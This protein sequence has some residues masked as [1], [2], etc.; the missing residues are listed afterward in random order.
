[1]EIIEEIPPPVTEESL[2]GKFSHMKLQIMAKPGGDT[3][4]ICI[5]TGTGRNMIDRRF[6]RQ[7]QHTLHKKVGGAIRGYNGPADEL[8]EYADFYF[9]AK[10]DDNKLVKLNAQAWVVDKLDANCLLGNAWLVPRSAKID[11]EKNNIHLPNIKDGITLPIMV[12]KPARSVVRKVTAS[13]TISLLPGESMYLPV[14]YIALPKGRSFMLSA[15][16]PAVAN[17]L[18][19]SKTPTV[20]LATNPTSDKL[21]IKRNTRLATIHECDEAAYF[22]TDARSAFK[23]L[24]FATALGAAY[25][26]TA[27]TQRT[28]PTGNPDGSLAIS[29]TSFDDNAPVASMGGEFTLNN[30]T[31]AVCDGQ[32]NGSVTPELPLDQQVEQSDSSTP[33][34]DAVYSMIDPE[35][36]K[37]TE[38]P[39]V[40]DDE[41]KPRLSEINTTLGIKAP[42]NA[43]YQVSKHGVRV[44]AGDPKHARKFRHLCDLYPKVWE[45]KGPIKVPLDRQMKVPLVDGYQNVKLNSRPYPLSRRDREVLDKVH[46]TL[47]AQGRM[48]WVHE[49]STFAHPVFVVWRKVHGE[50]KGRAVVDLRQLNKVAVPDSYPL[51]LVTDVMDSVRGKKFLTIVDAT[52]FFFQF[53][54]HPQHRDRF[55]IVSHRGLERSTVALMGFRNS[56][57]YAQ[58][59]MDQ[60]LK[61]HKTYCRAFIDDIIIYS[62]SFDEHL[63]HLETIFKLFQ[64]KNIAISP[65]KSCVGY[66]SIELLGFY[67]D[68]FGMANTDYRIQG[69]KDISFPNTLKSLEGY[70][71]AAGYLRTMIPYFAQIAEPLQKRKVALLAE[72]RKTGKITTSGTRSSYAK[73]RS[74]TSTPEE[75]KA[76]D[77]LQEHLCKRLRL[78]HCDPNRVLFLQIDGSLERG[79]G[80]VAF[81]LKPGATWQPKKA[82]PASDIEPVLFLSRCLTKAELHYGPSEL[83]VACLVWAC[84]RM[85]TMLHSCQQPIVVLTDHDA[86]RGI[87]NQ[88]SLNT[89]STDRA[90]RRLVN[91]SIYLSA[92]PLE[93]H[94]LAGRLNLVPDALSRLPGKGDD[95][96]RKKEDIPTLDNLWDDDLVLYAAEARMSDEMRA[97]FIAGYKEDTVF[98]KIITDLCSTPAS[99]QKPTILRGDNEVVVNASKA[100]HPFRLAEGLLYNRDND[101]VERLVVPRNLVPEIL[102]HYHDEKH[103]FGRERMLKDLQGIHFRKKRHLVDQY[104]S[105]CHQCGAIRQEN[106]LPVG[107]YTPIQAP[108]EPMHTIAMDFIVGLP[109]VPS[110][111]TPWHHA[112]FDCYDALLTVTCKSS[113]RTLLIPGHTEYTAEDW[114]EK[115]AA[116]LL[117]GDWACPQVIISDRDAKFTSRF[118]NALWKSFRTRLMMTTAHHPQ[119]DGQ[120]EV[121]N[122]VV[123]L[124]IR[125]HTYERP[126]EAWVNLIPSLQWD[127]NNAHSTAIDCS[128]HEYLFGFKIQ[129]TLDRL[130]GKTIPMAVTEMKFMRE[131]V[132]RDAQLAMDIAAATAKRIYDAK[133]RQVEFNEGDKVWLTLGK[134]Y[135]LPGSSAQSNKTLP[136]RDGPYTIIRKISPLAYELQLPTASKIHPVVSIQYLT[137]YNCDDDPFKRRQPEPGPLDY[138]SQTESD[139]EVYEVERIVDHQPKNGNKIR[140]YLVRW[141]GYGPKDD[142]WKPVSELKH[143]SELIEEYHERLKQQETL[144]GK[145]IER[146]K[147]KKGSLKMV[148][149]VDDPQQADSLPK[150]NLRRSERINKG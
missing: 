64:D 58:R 96:A 14:Q 75:R 69:F 110:A 46:D 149:F 99:G 80:V 40:L 104:V 51:P 136:R 65:S 98:G 139:D 107:E 89:T 85:R 12:T 33:Y 87:I 111:G 56:P 108:L 117:L 129:G 24:A 106:Q 17:A 135:K 47:H 63:Y 82:I 7:Y 15:T 137:P 23:A 97:K 55:T 74:F 138:H 45:D 34:L 101:G 100:G 61:E 41:A 86:T 142:T 103:H 114:A 71:G 19:D 113:K 42:E 133:H 105:K 121:K 18:V 29:S 83:E 54:V 127:L 95:E 78:A 28:V 49:A 94:H 4:G 27:D 102:H 145:T 43:P 126:D 36:S 25:T 125:Y 32:A 48:E 60:L 26:P 81:H 5:D 59:F 144:Q 120:S 128:P 119:S 147:K 57:A 124:A 44:Y 38:E 93:V 76:F 131:A 77:S 11:H 62:D 88:T 132:R 35:T 90:N 13:T 143:A 79:F 146:K 22:M 130:Q 91:A 68:A 141:V 134:A 30:Q 10:T 150:A 31:R 109:R 16:H 20:V 92:Y 50:D 115:L 9:Y 52:S 1:M 67:V 140:K 3:D 112:D 70:L 6:L 2:Q 8:G 53:L 118:W 122:K 116:H 39:I 66:P 72:G 37:P 148:K 21:T 84:K 73:S 123:E